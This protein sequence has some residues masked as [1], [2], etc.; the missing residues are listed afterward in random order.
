MIRFSRPSALS[1][2]EIPRC[3]IAMHCSICFFF[4]CDVKGTPRGMV[5]NEHGE[6]EYCRLCW[7]QLQ[8]RATTK[9]K[10]VLIH[11]AQDGSLDSNDGSSAQHTMQSRQRRKVLFAMSSKSSKRRC[12]SHTNLNKTVSKVANR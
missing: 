7:Q 8:I 2:A 1:P 12:A 10:S 6:I 11:S 3:L 5:Y 9:E 4:E